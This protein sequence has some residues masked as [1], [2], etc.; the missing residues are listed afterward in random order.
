MELRVAAAEGQDGVSLFRERSLEPSDAPALRASIRGIGAEATRGGHSSRVPHARAVRRPSR[1]ELR[2]SEAVAMC[3]PPPRNEGSIHALTV[4][5]DLVDR[6]DVVAIGQRFYRVETVVEA[7]SRCEFPLIVLRSLETAA[8]AAIEFRDPDSLVPVLRLPS[9]L[10][11]GGEIG[12]ARS[13]GI[14]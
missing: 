9:L 14:S 5:V 1:S 7:H 4:S 11:W 3:S 6:G 2:E 13:R 10:W 12:L 8:R